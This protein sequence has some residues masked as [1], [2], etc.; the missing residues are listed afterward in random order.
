MSRLLYRLGR[1]AASRPW[2]FIVVWLVIVAAVAGF[3]GAAGGSLHDN[4]TLAGTGSQQ[5]TDLLRE[6]FPALAGADARVVVHAKSGQVDKAKL[7]AA[8]AELRKL[9]HVSEVGPAQPSP[10]GATALLTVRYS[11]PVT[12]LAPGETLDR[13]RSATE[14]L[15]GYQ[16]EFGGQV[17]ENVT[18]PGGVAEA[19]GIVAALVI[20]FLAFGSVVAAGLPLAVALAGLGV[21]VSGITLVAAVTDVATTAPTLATMVGL[22]V[23]IDYALFILTRH[24]EGLAAGLDVPEAAGR[25]IAT[26]GLSVLFAGFTVLLALC[27]LV[28]SRIPVFMTMGF[29]TGLVVAATV[30]SALTLLPAVLGLAGRRVL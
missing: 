7:A 27:G 25:A 26:A 17:P 8:A 11:V 9:P 24:R 29:T 21:G 15:A 10:D 2:R 5:A 28:L 23:G 30:L 22:G 6:R 3:A 19:I 14:E 1:A 16:V 4:Y 18:A 20:L 12:D 13:L